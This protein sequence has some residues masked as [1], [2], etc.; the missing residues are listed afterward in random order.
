[1][2]SG[3]TGSKVPGRTD[4]PCRCKTSLLNRWKAEVLA[5][6]ALESENIPKGSELD[7]AAKAA[8]Q[9]CEQTR[10]DY[11]AHINEHGC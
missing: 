9:R 7:N 4:T 8:V 1:M 11:E 10:R 3:S 6:A 2:S 5:Y